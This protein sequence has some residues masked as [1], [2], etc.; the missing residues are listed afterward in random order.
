M[1]YRRP[2]RPRTG[3]V[4][5][6]LREQCWSCDGHGDEN[7]HDY[8][9]PYRQCHVCGGRG[10]EFVSRLN[11]WSRRKKYL[12][13]R[14]PGADANG[15]EKWIRFSAEIP[16][17]FEPL[18]REALRKANPGY[19]PDHWR[20]VVVRMALI[21]WLNAWLPEPEEPIDSEARDEPE[22][23]ESTAEEIP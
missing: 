6:L 16:P 7:H 9:L 4:P 1:K 19:A 20:P 12:G 8:Q 22:A 2:P 11:A 3:R 15:N 17:E 10:W 13:L 18:M 23:L 5:G 14:Q 21:E